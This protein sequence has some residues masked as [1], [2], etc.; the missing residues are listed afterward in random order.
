M[1][2]CRENSER[3]YRGRAPIG[4][5]QLQS[6]V[7]QHIQ[8]LVLQGHEFDG[9]L[10]AG[11]AGLD[12]EGWTDKTGFGL[13][14]AGV[15]ADTTPKTVGCLVAFHFKYQPLQKVGLV[16]RPNGKIQ[17]SCIASGEKGTGSL[18]ETWTPSG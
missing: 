1:I 18:N 15:D 16:V 12:I 14:E 6:D 5:D 9:G 2:N 4:V 10:F 3:I 11:H 17:G 13:G 8:P 7:F